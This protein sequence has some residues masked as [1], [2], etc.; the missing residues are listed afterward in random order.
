MEFREGV[1]KI[2]VI[3][4]FHIPERAN[5]IPD[6][7]ID[8]LAK[9]TKNGKFDFVLCTGDLTEEK[10]LKELAN[11]GIVKYVKGNMDYLNLPER[12]LIKVGNVRILLL[13]GSEVSPR[14]DIKQLDEIRKKE[15]A[16]IVVHG[17]THKMSLEKIETKDRVAVFVNPGTAT[18]AWG[19]SSDE[20][21]QTFVI[22]EIK[23]NDA[24]FIFFEDGKI[25]KEEVL[26][27]R[28]KR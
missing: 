5:R 15:D 10:I 21:S 28:K 9:E 2:L 6:W 8:I 16:D 18:G 24:R 4:D 17:H 14:G 20:T 19:G 7:I 12:E 13:H 27:I 25:K 22:I 23:D 1:K 26:C 11:F 3:G